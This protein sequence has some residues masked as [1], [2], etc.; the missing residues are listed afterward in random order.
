MNNFL[1][2][3]SNVIHFS[4][5]DQ[6]KAAINADN[7]DK[8]VEIDST[9]PKKSIRSSQTS[10]KYEDSK[11]SKVESILER[12][13]S[14]TGKSQY[15][16]N[17]SSDR[18]TFTD[19][20]SLRLEPYNTQTRFDVVSI[21][22]EKSSNKNHTLDDIL[23]EIK[24][25]NS[26][27][28]IINSIFVGYLPFVKDPFWFDLL[29]NAL[30]NRWPKGFYFL[31][32][33]LTY[34]QRGA[35]KNKS[36]EFTIS[37]V[38]SFKEDE[39]H[40]KTNKKNIEE[41][42]SFI[43]SKCSI[44]S[45]IDKN[46]ERLRLMEANSNK[47]DKFSR[48]Q[49]ELSVLDYV[50]LKA[51]EF[52]YKKNFARKILNFVNYGFSLGYLDYNKDLVFVNGKLTNINGLNINRSGFS[53]DTD[54]KPRFKKTLKVYNDRQFL[55]FNKCKY[56]QIKHK[57][58]WFN[59]VYKLG[60]NNPISNENNIPDYSTH[61]EKMINSRN[62]DTEHVEDIDFDRIEPIIVI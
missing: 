51:D 25:K 23:K 31:K 6:Q 18:L 13:S 57:M 21:R 42:F 37:E 5:N 22:R 62:E 19:R 30:Y 29:K 26:G 14:R 10:Q 41:M 27:K 15:Y 7:S 35:T 17:N 28:K 4:Q 44:R 46:N 59:Y 8:I 55:S 45:D 16:K 61:F 36:F 48:K 20:Y 50:I 60:E 32:D 1:L 33:K 52:N 2:D 38:L 53:F 34:I 3:D 43:K 40:E 39:N 56:K 11:N 49:R 58:N 12:K 47:V 54:R 9:P 24:A